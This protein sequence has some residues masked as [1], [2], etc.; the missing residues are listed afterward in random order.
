[1]GTTESESPI[2]DK[3]L[4]VPV[5][6]TVLRDLQNVPKD[7]G[8][9]SN[10]PRVSSTKRPLPERQMSPPQHQSHGSSA[11]NAQLVYVRRK[12]EADAVRNNACD[13]ATINAEC[14][15]SRKLSHHDAST[16]PISQ[17]KETKV[18]CVPAFAPFP[19]AASTILPGKPS[20][21][22]P[23][24]KSGTG[25]QPAGANCHP[26]TSATLP[27]GLKNLHWEGRFHQL[28]L[29]LRKLDQSEHE[30]YIQMLRS[31]SSVELS[32]LAVELE[33]RSIQL[34]LE[35]AKELQRVGCFNVLGKSVKHFNVPST[36]EDRSEK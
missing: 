15:V 6:K 2:H 12:S 33:K 21:L 17:A 28:Q 25:L 31:L 23:L 3:Q 5:K 8:R 24:C 19:V 29:L 35:E 30:D 1:M 32:R 34:S 7:I 16:R 11:A 14:Q 22:V 13:K 9:T 18:F 26:H 20:V 27:K 4:P 36:Q 10:V